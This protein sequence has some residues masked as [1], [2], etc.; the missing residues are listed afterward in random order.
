MGSSQD[1]SPRSLAHWKLV[2]GALVVV[3]LAVAM[4]YRGSLDNGFHFDDEQHIH[5]NPAVRIHELSFETLRQAVTGS[6]NA[7]RPLPYVTFA[8]DWWRGGGSPRTFQTTNVTLHALSSFALFALILTASRR[9]RLE[10]TAAGVIAALG[11]TLLWS[12]H[13]I[14]TQAVTYVVQRMAL[15]AGAFTVVSVL[16]YVRGRLTESP[17]RRLPWFALCLTAGVLGALSKQNAWITPALLV[18][19]ELG[20]VRNG[21]KLFRSRAE[22]LVL[23]TAVA[24]LLACFGAALFEVGPLASLTTGYEVR[25]F[26]LHDRIRTQPR[27]AIFH[28]S[29]I[30]WPLPSRFSIEHDFE[31]S[32]SLF[33]PIATL[34]AMGVVLVWC[35][36]GC[37]CLSRRGRRVVGFWM[38]WIPATLVIESTLVPLEMVFEHRMYLPSVGLAGLLG[39]CLAP[40][41]AG[42][43]G[44]RRGLAAAVAIALAAVLLGTATSRTLSIWRDPVVFAEHATRNAPNSARAWSNLALAYFQVGRRE[45]AE[46]ALQRSMSFGPDDHHNFELM[47]LLLMDRGRRTEARSFFTRALAFGAPSASLLNHLGE[48]EF[49]DGAH[50]KAADLF[51][52][53]ARQKPWIAVYHW[54]RALALEHLGRCAQA[55]DEWRAFGDLS[56]DA[57]AKAEVRAHLEEVHFSPGGRCHSP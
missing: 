9:S 35:A 2:A 27:V 38:L 32:T 16:A 42:G 44:S 51:E 4:T 15:L 14:Q 31:I 22:G 33:D 54:N 17:A 43:A 23:A 12:V 50:G 30:L 24:L 3:A 18:L 45:E 11:A 46:T 36:V 56:S 8:V 49:A 55:R 20:V 5:Q 52:R 6:P 41:F 21:E 13:P 37:W 10:S 39:A 25:D 1:G 47:G 29:Q 48:L 28:L 19:A 34:P 57:S 7:K 53:A 26:T 40:A